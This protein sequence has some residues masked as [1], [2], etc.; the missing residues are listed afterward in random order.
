LQ[1]IANT[2]TTLNWSMFRMQPTSILCFY[3]CI[4]LHWAHT[5]DFWKRTGWAQAIFIR[6]AT[7]EGTSNQ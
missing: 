7:T 4:Y 6:S 2:L 5:S 1:Y 3:L